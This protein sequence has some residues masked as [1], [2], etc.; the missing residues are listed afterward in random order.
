MSSRISVRPFALAPGCAAIELQHVT[1]CR[2]SSDDLPHGL[3]TCDERPSG[4]EPACKPLRG[5][6]RGLSPTGFPCAAGA[7][8]RM[9]VG[10]RARLQMPVA[11]RRAAR[12]PRRRRM[13]CA[14][15]HRR[16]RA[17]ARRL[18]ALAVAHW[19]RRAMI[20]RLERWRWWRRRWRWPRPA[21]AQRH[22]S[23]ALRSRRHAQGRAALRLPRALRAAPRSGGS[24]SERQRRGQPRG[25]AGRAART[26]TSPRWSSSTG[27]TSARPPDPE[28]DPNRCQSRL[29]RIGAARLVCKSQ[30]GARADGATPP[31]VIQACDAAVRQ[32]RRADHGQGLLP[33]PRAERTSALD[34]P[35]PHRDASQLERPASADSGCP[36]APTGRCR[37]A[38][39]PPRRAAG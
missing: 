19:R 1:A 18:G 32:G 7:L 36:L 13:D 33:R 2:A 9:R 11:P 16:R 38:A 34:H 10:S 3:P 35:E 12:D 4:R 23:A 30:C 39:R 31:S 37:L 22:R 15:A 20:R 8:S 6:S 21:R 27:A 17:L 5:C 25:S 14:R 24:S 28:P 26:A 29:L